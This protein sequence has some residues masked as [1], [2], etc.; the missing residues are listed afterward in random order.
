MAPLF[1]L[2]QVILVEWLGT[3]SDVDLPQAS[4]KPPEQLSEKLLEQLL[5]LVL[6]LAEPPAQQETVWGSPRDTLDLSIGGLQQVALQ[7]MELFRQEEGARIAVD[8]PSFGCGTMRRN[9]TL[10]C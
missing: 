5:A 3:V 6:V 9:G 4:G 2:P 7:T 8:A 10:A 1:L